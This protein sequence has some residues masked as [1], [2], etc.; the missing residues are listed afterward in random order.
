MTFD[1]TRAIL[2]LTSALYMVACAGSPAHVVRHDPSAAVE[3]R[4][5]LLR[6]DNA[7]RDR[8]DVYLVGEVRAWR[9]GRL[10]PG[11]ARWLTVPRDIPPSDLSRLQMV[12]LANAP[13]TITPM[14]DPRAV[15]TIRL[16][17]AML[18]S[19]RWAFVQGQLTSAR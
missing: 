2:A 9:I 15:S 16:P 13:V 7:G 6:F 11:Q 12:V 4:S 18:W 3:L 14:Q 5:G 19:Q 10:E 1:P 8:L 17:V